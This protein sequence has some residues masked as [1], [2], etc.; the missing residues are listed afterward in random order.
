MVIEILKKENVIEILK[1]ENVIEDGKID[2]DNVKINGG[3]NTVN[4]YLQSTS[5]AEV[6]GISSPKTLDIKIGYGIK[7]EEI[8]EE[9]DNSTD[10][11]NR[12]ELGSPFYKMRIS[13][14][15]NRLSGHIEDFKNMIRNGGGQVEIK[16][17]YIRKILGEG[18][19][20]YEDKSDDAIYFRLKNLLLEYGISVRLHHHY[21]ANLIMSFID[22]SNIDIIEMQRMRYLKSARRAGFLTNA[23]YKRYGQPGYRSKLKFGTMEEAIETSMYLGSYIKKEFI[24]KIFPGAMSNP[25]PLGP[26]STRSYDWVCKRVVKSGKENEEKEDIKIKCLASTI[27][28]RDELD[29]S[30]KD[31]SIKERIRKEFHWNISENKESDVFV[32]TGWKDRKSLELLKCWVI[33]KNDI[34]NDR[35]FC[36]LILSYFYE[37]FLG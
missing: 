18:Y 22:I 10:Y 1:K 17:K 2:V 23:Q 24:S 30:W 35:K 19:G 7:V 34:I 27:R 8:K 28:T 15:R 21:G 12:N 4:K 16:L 13:D 5:A 32:L 36:P 14:Y 37:I 25:V 9:S 20:T 31:G 11:E 33:G 29:V 26:Y 6:S 3:I